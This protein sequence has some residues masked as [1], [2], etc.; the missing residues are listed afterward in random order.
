MLEYESKYCRIR[1]VPGPVLTLSSI[2]NI[3]RNV[4]L[5]GTNNLSR[6]VNE[7]IRSC[8][9]KASFVPMLIYLFIYL[10]K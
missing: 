10:Q 2:T 4:L 6:L 9:C 7:N 8:D 1:K 5:R 3:V